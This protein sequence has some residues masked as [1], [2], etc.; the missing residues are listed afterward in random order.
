M[1]PKLM[2][3]L[4]ASFLSACVQTG[5]QAIPST[6]SN[7][8]TVLSRYHWQLTDARTAQKQRVTALFVD[9]QPA[10]QLDFTHGHINVSNA[11][12]RL[13]G[14]YSI[15]NQQISFG[16]LATS[17]RACD[18]PLMKLDKAISRRLQGSASFLVQDQQPPQLTLTLAS[19]EVLTFSATPTAETRY[20]SSGETMFLE[21]A[22][23][24]RTCS[25]PLIPNKQCLQIREVFFDQQGLRTGTPGAWQHLYQDIDGFEH[26]PGVRN[27]LRVK[28]FKIANPPADASNIAYVLDMVVESELSQSK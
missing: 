25:H 4:M 13:F 1:K 2:V 24:T 5:S 6:I 27:I 18:A 20:G 16:D 28:R 21:V 9:S 22:A 17:M 26:Q 19:G 8:V 7:D 15:K 11:C 23:Q 12:N 14:A 3:L 10:L